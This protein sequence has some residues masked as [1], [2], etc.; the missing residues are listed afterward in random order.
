M[1]QSPTKKI[2]QYR[3]T[4]GPM[5]SDST[6]GAN[7]VFQIPFEGVRLGVVASDGTGWNESELSGI[8]W[9]HVSV[10]LTARCPT[11]SEM[12]FIKS[13]FWRDD[14]TVLQF[15]V[16]KTDHVN[17]HQYCLHLWKPVGVEIPRPPAICVGP[18]TAKETP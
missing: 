3:V 8:A 16:P 6:I 11:W 13:I 12:C 15:H 1:R 9:E 18:R 17:Y 14:E 2:E 7:G 10:S 4:T 5:A